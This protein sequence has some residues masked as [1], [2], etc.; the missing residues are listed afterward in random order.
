MDMATLGRI[1][2]GWFHWENSHAAKNV[3]NTFSSDL[4]QSFLSR[5]ETDRLQV[6]NGYG[7]PW[8]NR[9]RLVPLGEQPRSKERVQQLQFRSDPELPLPDRDRS[10]PSPEW[11]W[12]PLAE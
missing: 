6:L 11:I 3:Y 12:P 4:I 9:I 1:G 2:S 8:Q 7:H 5:I 10:T